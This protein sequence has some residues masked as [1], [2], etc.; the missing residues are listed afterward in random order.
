MFR[1][2]C[3]TEKEK[4]NQCDIRYQ[5]P[6]TQWIDRINSAYMHAT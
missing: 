5:G 4:N 1:R 3:G 2:S 6:H